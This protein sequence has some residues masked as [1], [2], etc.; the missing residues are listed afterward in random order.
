MSEELKTLLLKNYS[1]STSEPYESEDNLEK[2][3]N[4][5]LGFSDEPIFKNGK[6]EINNQRSCLSYCIIL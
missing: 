2:I 6:D 3:D 5:I 1:T 4:S